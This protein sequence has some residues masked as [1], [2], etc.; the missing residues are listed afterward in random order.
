MTIFH[1]L[2]RGV[3]KRSIVEDDSDRLRFVHSLFVFNDVKNVDPNHASPY[4]REEADARD[5][6]VNL[7]AWCLMGN[8][9]H[10]LL[11]AVNDDPANIS[12]FLKKLNMGYAKYFNEKYLRTGALWQ[13][14]SKKI[15][16]GS[17]PHFERI[18]FYIHLNPLDFKLPE[19]REGKIKNTQYALDTLSAYRWSSHL[20]YMGEN[21]WPSLLQK[22][23]LSEVFGTRD[24]YEQLIC[25]LI[26]D[27]SQTANASILEK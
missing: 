18:P 11:S 14:K 27:S 20:D 16:I 25:E 22:D 2:N 7:Y 12:T 6:L 26:Q 8:H 24:R 21:N 17:Q 15:E 13:G 5:R 19:W 1:V 3:D 23:L 10:M 9:Y 4:W